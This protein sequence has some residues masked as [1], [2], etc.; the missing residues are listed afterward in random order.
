MA[1]LGNEINSLEVV[2]AFLNNLV[3]LTQLLDVS[4]HH[5]SVL[6]MIRNACLVP[7]FADPTLSA[8]VPGATLID[9]IGTK[10]PTKDNFVHVAH[11]GVLLHLVECLL[12]DAHEAKSDF[13]CGLGRALLIDEVVL[14]TINL[15]CILN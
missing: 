11:H 6:R 7:V 5:D 2:H 12:V 1:A 4:L 14:N 10:D 9:V 13:A 3:Q 8:V 15:K